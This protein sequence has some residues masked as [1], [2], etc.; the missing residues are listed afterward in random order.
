MNKL[1]SLAMAVCCAGLITGCE[2]MCT[3]DGTCAMCGEKGMMKTHSQCAKDGCCAS[4]VCKAKAHGAACTM[5]KEG[6]VNT[7]ALVSMIRAKTP[8]TVLDARAGKY[9]DGNRIPG[10]KALAPDATEEQVAAMVPDKQALVV[11]YCV[12]L[13]CPASHMLGERL[14]QLGYTNVLEY[15]EGIEGWMAAGNE[16]EKVAH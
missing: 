7:A 3:K 13:K 2:S 15:H 12:N 8:M 16:I 9:D 4:G 5:M 10:A 6:A 1:M 14:R 11:T